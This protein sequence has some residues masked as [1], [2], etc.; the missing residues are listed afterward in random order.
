MYNDHDRAI[1][2]SL[3]Q[4]TRE[5]AELPLMADRRKRWVRHNQLQPE[6]PLVLVFPEGSWRE[7]LPEADCSCM[8]AAARA[9]EWALR[10]RIYAH[11]HIYDD[12]VVEPLWIVPKVV[13]ISGWGLEPEH[14]PTSQAT[15]AWGF[16]PVIHNEAD[17]DKLVYPQVVYDADQTRQNLASAQELYGDILD[18]QLRGVAHISFHLMSLYCQLRGLDQV[19]WDMYDNPGMLHHAMGILEEGSRR[20]V[21]QYI[22]L[23]LLSLNNDGTYHSS[24][25]VGY[26]EELPAAD[27]SGTVRPRDMWASAEAQEM[28]QVS[29]AMHSEFILAYEK[30]LLEPFGLTGYGC[31]E[32]LTE[33]LP[34]VLTIPHIRRI[35][36]SPFA[37]V[38]R[39]A[40]QLSNRAIFSWKPHPAHLV[41][42]F[43]AGMVK[44]YIS[45]TIAA[46]RAN[47][48]TLEIIL[49]DTH[50][51][52]QHPERFSAWTSIAS[53]LVRS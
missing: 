4:R 51:C 5:I 45:Q 35:S 17:L 12:T 9:E 42:S 30:R 31:C 20:L 43:D 2:R 33:K 26:T 8:D 23:N 48:C 13:H 24:G 18:V 15:G 34:E 39:C 36:I 21:Q 38:R 6:R 44:E 52:E 22:D 49:K 46:A 3:A 53:E 27:Y 14:Q 32:N 16:K 37:D 25:G 28:A 41:G 7:L 50:T 40:E 11:E 10:A 19:M 47:G 1:L 29:P